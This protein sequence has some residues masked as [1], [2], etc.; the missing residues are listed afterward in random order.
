[1]IS[2]TK[3][4]FA[5]IVEFLK[6]AVVIWLMWPLLSFQSD[7]MTLW[8]MVLGVLLAVLFLGKMFYDFIIDNFKQRK[9]RYTVV[10]FLILVGFIA[11]IAVLVGGG[12][13]VF[14]LYLSG[15]IRE[16]AAP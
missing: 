16:S 2:R 15:Q 10:D 12:M 3:N 13:L 1:M 4:A 5:T 8:R 14:G 9:E 6:W 11:G 7:K